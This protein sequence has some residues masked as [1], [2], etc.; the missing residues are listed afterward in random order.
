VEG[1]G[2]GK[3]EYQS[4]LDNF[5]KVFPRGALWVAFSQ[6]FKVAGNYEWP[7]TELVSFL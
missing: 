4:E 7:E 6:L 3:L 5:F 1:F 2:K